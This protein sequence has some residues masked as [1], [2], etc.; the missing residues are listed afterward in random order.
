MN[1]RVEELWCSALRSGKF[2]QG[3]NVLSD[4][5]SFCCLGVLCELAAEENICIKGTD[6]DGIILYDDQRSV[7]PESVMAWAGLTESNPDVWLDQDTPCLAEL[8]DKG[9]AFSTLADLI[10]INL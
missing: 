9:I 2:P 1:D 7:L 10:E 3:R 6:T 8:N 5:I 4:G